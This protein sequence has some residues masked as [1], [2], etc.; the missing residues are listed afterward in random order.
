[1]RIV[2]VDDS[3]LRATVL[4]EG[5]REAGYDD[6]HLVPPRGAFVAR[7]ERMAPDVVLIDLG[8]PSRDTLEEMLTVSRALA[9]PIAMFVDQSDDTMIEAAIDAGI[10]AYVVDGLR[11]ERVKPIINLAVRR[12]NAF[13]RMQTEL[14]EARTELADRKIIDRAKAI[15]IATRG[16]SEPDAYAALRKAA[17]NQNKKIVDVASALITASD[18]LGGGV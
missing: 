12:F 11:K 5:L 7:I 8:N 3:G 15:L 9:K 13:A 1:M 17:M 6:I 16:L 18:L 14:N 4:E 10:S 2:I